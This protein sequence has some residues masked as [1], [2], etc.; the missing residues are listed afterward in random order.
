MFYLIIKLLHIIAVILFLGNIFTGLFWMRIAMKTKD[1]NIIAH[2]IKGVNQ[3]DR[4]FTIPGVLLI[5]AF[6]LWA[7][8]KG[9]FPII[10][11]GWILWSIIFFSLS[12]IAFM[13]KVVPLQRKMEEITKDSSSDTSANRDSLIKMFREWEIWGAVALITPFIALVMMVLKRPL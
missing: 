1:W 12:G 2:T 5:T 6:G 7:A 9:H 8:I 3:S 10:G 11:T 13:C 4:L